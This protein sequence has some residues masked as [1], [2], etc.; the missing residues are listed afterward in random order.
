M[1]R[2]ETHRAF[3]RMPHQSGFVASTSRTAHPGYHPGHARLD[4]IGSDP[5][6]INVI[7]HEHPAENIS[8]SSRINGEDFKR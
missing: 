7:V 2:L 8:V 1:S 3:Y 4:R 6:I 5:K